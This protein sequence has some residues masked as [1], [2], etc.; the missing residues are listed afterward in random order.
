MRCRSFIALALLAL[1]AGCASQ[2]T[3]EVPASTTFAD[4]IEAK[5]VYE[6]SLAQVMGS[7][8]V[9]DAQEQEDAALI[10]AIDQNLYPHLFWGHI[11]ADGQLIAATEGHTEGLWVLFV[12][13]DHPSLD[14]AGPTLQTGQQANLIAVTVRPDRISP[15]F[16]GVFLTH[17]M[18]H[19][20]NQL[21]AEGALPEA[22]EYNAYSVEKAAYNYRYNDRLD[23]LLDRM[24]DDHNIENHDDFVAFSEAEDERL[25]TFLLD[26]DEGLGHGPAHSPAEHE[27]RMGFYLMATSIRV[28]ER[29]GTS[30]FDN[31]ARLNRLLERFSRYQ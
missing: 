5:A 18:M 1:L 14:Q 21:F 22:S 24:L 28:G 11:Q 13:N 26:I 29:S 31:T 23:Q 30:F 10:Q 7:V 15:A 8:P 2:T 16:A 25:D 17:E 3:H 12:N 9:P 6:K 20:F 4:W 19:G 27:M